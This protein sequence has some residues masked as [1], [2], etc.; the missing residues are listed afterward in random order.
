MFGGGGLRPTLVAGL[1]HLHV[2]YADV[3]QAQTDDVY[4]G[5][6]ALLEYRYCTSSE[7]S[8]SRHRPAVSSLPATHPV[9]AYKSDFPTRFNCISDADGL[10]AKS[11]LYLNLRRLY[12]VVQNVTLLFIE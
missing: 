6:P 9:I 10:H 11:D 7:D 8:S 1:S 12:N 3:V 5:R 4:I 2:I